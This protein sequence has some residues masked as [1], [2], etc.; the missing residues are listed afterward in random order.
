M[1]SCLNWLGCFGY[2]KFD[3]VKHKRLSEKLC[4]MW[5]VVC[6]DCMLVKALHGEDFCLAYITFE[7][8]KSKL[9]CT[10]I[11][12]GHLS[13]V[14]HSLSK[15][16]QYNH[17][18]RRLFFNIH[19]YIFLNYWKISL[20]FAYFIQHVKHNQPEHM[21]AEQVENVTCLDR[22]T[23]CQIDDR[24]H[25]HKGLTELQ[26]DQLKTVPYGTTCMTCHFLYNGH[27]MKILHDNTYWCLYF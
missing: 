5:T 14:I 20:I 19:W 17:T 10:K 8:T 18:V 1:P 6:Q 7:L 12:L 25:G 24:Q 13:N 3:T 16:C 2:D 26:A 21:S 23:H 27:L 22:G 9:C 15:L 11:Y 4:F